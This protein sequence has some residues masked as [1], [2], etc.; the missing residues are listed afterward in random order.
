M[1]TPVLHNLRKYRDQLAS[2]EFKRDGAWLIYTLLGFIVC[3]IVWAAWFEI[4]EITRGMGKIIPSTEVKLVQHLEGGVVRKI[5]VR[6]GDTVK[7]GDALIVLDPKRQQASLADAQSELSA[8]NSEIYRH[9]A[10]LKGT[11][12]NVPNGLVRQADLAAQR[13]AYQ[14]EKARFA[15]EMSGID[16]EISRLQSE[17]IG[18][19]NN[20]RTAK[21]DVKLA[22]ENL[23]ITRRLS[24]SG[25]LSDYER[26]REERDA[27]QATKEQQRLEARTAELTQQINQAR[28][29]K[30]GITQQ[31]QAE[32][33]TRLSDL[34]AKRDG[35]SARENAAEDGV[36]RSTV[37]SPVNGI[38]KN[39]FV[40]AEGAVAQPGAPLVEVVPGED[41]L[42]VE[43]HIR[44]QDIG[45][46]VTGQ[47]AVIKVTAYDFAVYGALVGEVEHIS[48]DTIRNKE[49][50]FYVVRARI[51]NAYNKVRL[52][53][54][55]G[56][57]INVDI[58]TGRKSVLRF[59]SK[60]ITRG[61]QEALT[62]R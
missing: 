8:I 13:L 60:P 20:H 14:T 52:D 31:F 35:I 22:Q 4:D 58:I 61:I 39:V 53:L 34:Y 9:E 27:L 1:S 51:K 12:L 62:E 59:I 47:K 43:A 24:A 55:S 25:G 11:A 18:V 45:F 36:D 48:A 6:I 42:L 5:N 56:M 57:T 50:E 26:I 38:V 41:D 19:E 40:N 2:F 30:N 54:K 33:W 37:R 29:R 28:A 49:E 44:P 10:L 7:A 15:A 46:I 16:A 21:N 23:A 32:R 17:L 3:S